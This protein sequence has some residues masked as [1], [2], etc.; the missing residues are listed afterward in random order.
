M[1]Q[2]KVFGMDNCPGCVTVKTLL[3]NKGVEFIEYDVMN[4]DHMDE[5]QQN[6]IRSVP[7]VIVRQGNIEHVYTGSSKPTLDELMAKVGE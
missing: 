5:C 4:V 3:K 7:T 1:K 6:L 2:V